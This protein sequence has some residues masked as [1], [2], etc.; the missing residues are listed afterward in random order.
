MDYIASILELLGIWIIGNKSKWGFII[1]M[2][3]GLCWMIYVGINKHTYG[4]L[5]VVLPALVINTRNFIKWS[6]NEN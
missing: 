6:K 4:I 3:A 5:L 2:I 1:F